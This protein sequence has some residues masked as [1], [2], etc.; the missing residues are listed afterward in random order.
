MTRLLFGLLSLLPVVGCAR[1]TS[2][3]TAVH[4]FEV[5]RY[6]GVWYET[7]RFPHRFENG[8][9]QVSAEYSRRSDGTLRVLNK[10]FNPLSGEW[11]QIEGT[12]RFTETPDIGWLEVCF[13][14]PFW[15]AYK[16]VALDTDTYSWAI[17]TGNTDR[18]LW[19]LTRQPHPPEETV[20]KLI[21]QARDLGFD[22]Q[23]LIR[24]NQTD[25]SPASL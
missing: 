18:Y 22:T 8:L 1:S 24:V 4:P 23:R 15:G 2:H 25:S 17:V 7:A 10:G 14:K 16:I 11:K 21:E 19:I 13:F 12:A 20:Q 5:E 6:L 9:E 3:L